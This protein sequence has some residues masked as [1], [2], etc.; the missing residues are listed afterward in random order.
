MS[1]LETSWYD[2]YYV[3]ERPPRRGSDDRNVNSRNSNSRTEE[4]DESGHDIRWWQIYVQAWIAGIVGGLSYHIICSYRRKRSNE[5]RGDDSLEWNA[6]G[7][8][9]DTHRRLSS[10]LCN[11]TK[12]WMGTT[13]QIRQK[14]PEWVWISAPAYLA[15]IVPNN[16][17]ATTKW[18]ILLGTALI[19]GGNWHWKSNESTH[20]EQ[21]HDD[22]DDDKSKKTTKERNDLFD[23]TSV[24]TKEVSTHPDESISKR[25]FVTLKHND[26]VQQ[27]NRAEMNKKKEHRR[28]LELLVHNVS[29]TDLVLSLD[30]VANENTDT[31]TTTVENYF[32][33]RFSFFDH[34]SRLVLESIHKSRSSSTHEQDSVVYFPLY[35]R[36]MDARYSIKET[37]LDCNSPMA[38]SG[39]KLGNPVLLSR[40]NLQ[41]DIRIR[42]RDQANIQCTLHDETM[43]RI[44]AKISH[45]F[46]PLLAALLPVWE[47][48]IAEKKYHS[49]AAVKRILILVT[50][51]GTPRNWTHSMTG[52]STKTCADLMQAFLAKIDPELT[53]V[54]IHSETNIFRYDENILFCE[55]ELL[56]TVN[57]YRDAHATGVP[58]PDEWQLNATLPVNETKIDLNFDNADWRKSMSVTL[59]FADGSPA[60]THAIQ[61][62]LRPYRP[63][64]FHFWQLKTFWHESKIVTDDIEVHSFE[65]ME[66]LPPVDVDRIQ[67]GRIHLVVQEMK[68]F[69]SEMVLTLASGTNDIRR[70]WLRKTGKPVLAVLLVQTSEMAEPRLFRGTNMEVSMP[71]GSLCA[72]RAA[73]GSALAANPNLR[74]QDLKLIAVLAVPPLEQVIED[75]NGSMR[76]NPSFSSVIE[77]QSETGDVRVID[78]RKSS[79]GSEYEPFHA[80]EWIMPTDA[81]QR[82]VLNSSIASAVAVDMDD[83]ADESPLPLRRI[84]LFSKNSTRKSKRTV[85]VQ[86]SKD[87][88]PL[89]PCGACNEWLK[90][91]AESN[92]Y[93]KI[94]T[95]TDANCNGIYVSPCQE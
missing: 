71:T 45:V 61:A 48:Q 8:L 38:A 91:I 60:R 69:Y 7:G 66:T 9:V 43:E 54:K 59:S 49:Q 41:H 62:S 70:F 63:T 84:A 77:D 68:R 40:E 80:D 5:E 18:G 39:I 93:F 78:S 57:A 72:E 95:F 33:P 76:R 31:T 12:H 11:K 74:R 50:G 88:N 92:P 58:Y 13:R 29:H 87:I 83:D 19:C 44:H 64:Y 65:T 73:I 37:P 1:H 3:V 17:L 94:I 15:L 20:P 35:E 53:V 30:G 52:N 2:H 21:S 47:K 86:S 4:R 23:V 22:D 32:R 27:S 28:Y 51:V 25:P 90:K 56:P 24:S 82:D 10:F 46:F 6:R 55:N 79:I 34:Y 36:S 89:A 16:S 85:V 67:D 14:I 81:I 42:G 26:G 75:G